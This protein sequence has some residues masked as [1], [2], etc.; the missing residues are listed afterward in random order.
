M[1]ALGPGVHAGALGIRYYTRNDYYTVLQRHFSCPPCHFISCLH[2]RYIR[3]TSP[4]HSMTC[5]SHFGASEEQLWF[6]AGCSPL[7]TGHAQK[8]MSL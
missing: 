8:V 2:Q 7:C 3:D 1:H 6:K 5:R 4:L